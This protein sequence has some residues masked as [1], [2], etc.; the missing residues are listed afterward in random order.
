M[1]SFFLLLR[2]TALGAV[3]GALASVQYVRCMPELSSSLFTPPDAPPPDVLSSMRMQDQAISWEVETD[4]F[5]HGYQG[6]AV[7]LQILRLGADYVDSS[8]ASS[9]VMRIV[10]FLPGVTTP[11]VYEHLTDLTL[12]CRWDRNYTLFAKFTGTVPLKLL[13]DEKLCRPF[14]TVAKKRP[15]CSGNVC[16]L[17]PDMFCVAFDAN[18]FCHRVGGALL[19]RF[20]LADRLFQYERL[21]SVYSFREAPAATDGKVVNAVKFY[22]V[23]F[24]GSK[25]ARQA[26]AEAAPELAAWLQANHDAAPCEEVDVNFQHILL[27][28]VADA[29]AQLF[30]N[31]YQIRQLCRMGSMVDERSTKLVYD[32]CKDTLHR[33][34]SG[35]AS[36]PGTLFVMTSANNVSLPARLPRWA[37]RM[38]LGSVSRTAY[39]RLLQACR[40]YELKSVAV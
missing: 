10:G 7:P 30:S 15:D 24:S 38:I 6:G 20:G 23:L 29:E 33:F 22:D 26:A 32:V 27:V 2:A 37:Q 39:G 25:R 11:T 28:P 40:E 17:V 1:P 16:T 9:P 35:A 31:A 3:G 19:R 21:S 13:E 34:S 12:R 36:S 5:R 4:D 18:W 8:G 14:A